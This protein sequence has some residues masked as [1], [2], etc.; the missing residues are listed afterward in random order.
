MSGN[1]TATLL[2]VVLRT[3]PVVLVAAACDHDVT[4]R[5]KSQSPPMAQPSRP[6]AAV[7]IPQRMSMA[8]YQ[9]LAEREVS[10]AVQGRKSRGPQDEMLRIEALAPGFAGFYKDS[11]GALVLLITKPANQL[12]A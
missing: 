9:K 6:P 10:A 3:L 1:F 8:E 11:T 7:A 2:R 5:G 12:A 4:P